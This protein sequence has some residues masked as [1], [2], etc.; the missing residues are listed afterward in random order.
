MPVKIA[1]DEARNFVEISAHGEL[2]DRMVSDLVRDLTQDPRLRS[3]FHALLDCTGVT[4]TRFD[5]DSVLLFPG[6]KSLRE[7]LRSSRI[8]AVIQEPAGLKKAKEYEALAGRAFK[9]FSSVDVAK[10]WL[11]CP[12]CRTFQEFS[13]AFRRFLAENE[14][15]LTGLETDR[16]TTLARAEFADRTFCLVCLPPGVLSDRLTLRQKEIAL[17]VAEGLSNKEIAQRLGTSPATI[18]SH[19][20]RIFRKY[21]IESRA[22]LAGAALR[23][24]GFDQKKP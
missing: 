13:E 8:A 20:A 9:A 17:L 23:L 22:R 11:G 10:A 4:S 12:P 15:R 7:L 18:A 6:A 3:G 16:F 19:M 24:V 2:T 21:K 1:V 5:G 14:S